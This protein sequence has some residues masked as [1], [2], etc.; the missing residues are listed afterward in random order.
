MS[1]GCRITAPSPDQYGGIESSRADRQR[2]G[3]PRSYAC[4]NHLPALADI[5][6]HKRI[7][8]C[9]QMDYPA[10]ENFGQSADVHAHAVDRRSVMSL[11][12]GELKSTGRTASCRMLRVQ[13]A[14]TD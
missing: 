14:M 12:S 5:V 13:S 1:T 2:I 8:A 10:Q 3:W 11:E 7:K 6:H 9:L 4:A